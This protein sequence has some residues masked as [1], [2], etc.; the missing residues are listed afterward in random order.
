MKFEVGQP[1]DPKEQP[2]A[3]GVHYQLEDGGHIVYAFF[4]DPSQS[5]VSAYRHGKIELAVFVARPVIFLLMQAGTQ[6]WVDAP[7][8]WHLV[9]DSHKPSFD[10]SEQDMLGRAGSSGSELLTIIMADSRNTI[11]R[12]IRTVTA[13]EHV[14][15]TIRAE[16]RLQASSPWDVNAFDRAMADATNRYTTEAML[17]RATARGVAG[18]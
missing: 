17:A 15:A 14:T 1:I 10:A 16:M 7:F 3:E 13:P 8:S 2:R 9:P 18:K 6:P 11:V 4:E 5:E 12:A